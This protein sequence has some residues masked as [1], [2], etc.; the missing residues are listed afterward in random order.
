MDV[1]NLDDARRLRERAIEVAQE[2]Q[3]AEKID[4]LLYEH[5]SMATAGSE[6][7]RILDLGPLQ[8]YASPEATNSMRIVTVQSGSLPV[9]RCENGDILRFRYG[10]WIEILDREISDL[11]FRQEQRDVAAVMRDRAQEILEN[12]EPTGYLP[13]PEKEINNASNNE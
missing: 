5:E 1:N 10:V 9:Y 6:H 3:I 2:L 11:H 12:F 8:L 13:L 4:L 7:A